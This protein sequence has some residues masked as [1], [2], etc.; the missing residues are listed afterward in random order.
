MTRPLSFKE[1][2][3]LK[4]LKEREAVTPVVTA[5]RD[6]APEEISEARRA[7]AK[8]LGLEDHRIHLVWAGFVPKHAGQ[9]KTEEEWDNRWAVWVSKQLLWDSAKA[10]AASMSGAKAADVQP[11]WMREAMGET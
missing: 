8:Q 9:K 11:S 6:A 7:K 5:K 2:L 10:P 1:D 3:D 4:Y